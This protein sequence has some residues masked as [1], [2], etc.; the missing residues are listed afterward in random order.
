MKK[1]GFIQVYTGDG[2]GKTTAA[3]GLA[4]RA[5]GH[6]L[7]VSVVQFL[8]SAGV[9]GETKEAA[10]LPGLTIIPSGRA[11]FVNLKAPDAADCQ[12]AQEGFTLAKK[13]ILAHAADII[14]L[15][16]INLAMNYHLLD[17]EEVLAFLQKEKYETEIILTGKD[18]PP[19]I[20]AIADLVTEMKKVKHTFDQDIPPRRGIDY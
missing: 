5:A 4:L 12:L 11:G 9:Y 10:M 16:E 2:K 3:L 20:L 17:T 14:V 15:D 19:E 7:R 1:S 18:A 6:G 13:I 8:K